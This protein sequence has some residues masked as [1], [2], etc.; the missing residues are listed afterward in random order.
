MYLPSSSCYYPAFLTGSYEAGTTYVFSK[1]IHRGMTVVDLGAGVGYYTLLAAKAVGTQGTVYAF[2]PDPVNYSFLLRNV[3][4]NGYHNVVAQQ[5]AVSNTIGYVK[6]FLDDRYSGHSLYFRNGLSKRAL[7]VETTTLDAFFK[8]K[9]WPRVDVVKMDIEGAEKFALEGMQKLSERNETLKLFIEFA[10]PCQRAAGVKDEDF[11]TTL[12]TLGFGRILA[13][14][15]D[16]VQLMRVKIPEDIPRLR[17]MA[18]SS[19]INLFCEK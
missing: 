5:K 9:G 17:S 16:P 4:V 18:G 10:P 12:L 7:T 6:L 1:V 19:C 13:I 2:E 8:E 14:K 3:K 15:D 11:F